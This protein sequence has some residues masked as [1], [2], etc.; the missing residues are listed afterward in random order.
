[1]PAMSLL[2][3]VLSAKRESWRMNDDHAGEH[4]KRFHAIRVK[5]LERDDYTCRF[6]GFRAPRWQEVHHRDDNH[7]NN[8]MANLVTACTLCHQCH[9]VGNAGMR[10]SGLLVWM[11][12]IA[13]AELNNVVRAIF[14]AVAAGGAMEPGARALYA[15]FE[16][17]AT[18]LEQSLGAGASD[19]AVLGQS[20]LSMEPAQ[21]D[22]RE[23]RLGG[24]RL[25]AKLGP[26]A[27]Q[28]AY[29]QAERS[30]F[31]AFAPS[32]WPRL[33][34]PDVDEAS[35]AL[36][37]DDAGGGA[38]NPSEGGTARASGGAARGPGPAASV[39]ADE[40]E[41]LAAAWKE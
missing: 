9:H 30:A 7:A 20:F 40:L 29:W 21:Y 13:Q 39:E 31:G 18:V 11:P 33:V 17:R 8:S 19:P 25:L 41:A 23:A 37:E 1:M 28:V 5:V 26:F 15:S 35:Y 4:D 36:D 24:L 6:C 2:P 12:E 38:A 22:S 10:R 32:D 14:V 34:A 16:A 3:I 27:S